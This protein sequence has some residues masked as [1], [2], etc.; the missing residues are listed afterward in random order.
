MKFIETEVWGFKHAFRGMRNPLNSWHL[1][2]SKFD[3]RCFIGPEDMQLAQKLIK[4]GSEHCKF[5]RQIH[6]SVDVD[7]PRYY[8]SEHDTY[9]FGTKNMHDYYGWLND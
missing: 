7:M 2:D 4:A 1:A 3:D 6:V 5:L 8:W 9:H